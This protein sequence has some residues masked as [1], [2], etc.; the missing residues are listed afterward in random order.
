[1]LSKNQ[2]V[3]AYQHQR[4][5]MSPKSHGQSADKVKHEAAR[6]WKS[7]GWRQASFAAMCVNKSNE[8]NMYE[9][10][11]NARKLPKADCSTTICL[12]KLQ[13]HDFLVWKQRQHFNFCCAMILQNQTGILSR[14]VK[15]V[16][17]VGGR[18]ILP[19]PNCRWCCKSRMVKKHVKACH[20]LM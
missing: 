4:S 8:P 10:H 16:A 5:S 20:P 7:K 14:I 18:K 13:N 2:M 11:K 3:T 6:K 12:S 1:M 17:K 19:N 15:N 9:N